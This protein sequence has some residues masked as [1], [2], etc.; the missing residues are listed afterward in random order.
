MDNW[1]AYPEHGGWGQVPRVSSF[2]FSPQPPHASATTPKC[3]FIQSPPS[4]TPP[5]PPQQKKTRK[6]A[7]AGSYFL[8]PSIPANSSSAIQSVFA[9]RSFSFL[10]AQ[11]FSNQ[12]RPCTMAPSSPGAPPPGRVLFFGLLAPLRTPAA[13]H[14]PARDISFVLLVLRASFDWS[15]R[16]GLLENGPAI[17][18]PGCL[19]PA[20]STVTGNW[21]GELSLNP[22]RRLR[23]L[24]RCGK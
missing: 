4:T 13:V 7:S 5:N 6:E 20:A 22:E 17:Q 14:T 12:K 9:T 8:L 11:R 24:S 15:A 10:L 2:V 21:A 16:S 1:A 3:T 18:Q 23:V 19:R